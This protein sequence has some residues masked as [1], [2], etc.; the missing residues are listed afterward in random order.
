MYLESF[1]SRLQ[2]ALSPAKPPKG[3]TLNDNAKQ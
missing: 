2:A 3:G 1:E